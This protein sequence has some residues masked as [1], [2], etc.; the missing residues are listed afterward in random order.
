MRYALISDIHANL[1]AL[2]SVLSH[3]ETQH[4]D[5]IVCLGDIVG[6]GP[7]PNECIDLIAQS[8]DII[9]TGNHDF[10]CIDSDEKYRFNQYARIAIEWTNSEL[11]EASRAV[12]ND[13]KLEDRIDQY[14]LVHSSPDDP[15][16]WNYIITL[17]HAI[18]NFGTF[19]DVAC[20]LGHTHVPVVFNKKEAGSYGLI[21]NNPVTLFQ[22]EQYL[23]NVGS[24]G[25][26]RD[27]NVD[28]SYGI[29]DTSNREYENIRIPYDV[30]KTQTKMEEIGLPTFLINR[31]AHG[32]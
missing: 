19:D 10:S 24:V 6:Y 31:M 3:I 5:S 22:T 25:Q 12:L 20:F 30:A 13:V 23:I 14:L 11:T 29:L 18:E 15:I 27:G 7:S 28:A 32:R 16:M 26:P 4:I 1:E 9:L 17:E 8:C 2:I 21:R